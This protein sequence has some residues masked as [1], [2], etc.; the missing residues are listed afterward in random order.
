MSAESC[1]SIDW[2]CAVIVSKTSS[3]WTTRAR[4][5]VPTSSRIVSAGPTPMSVRTSRAK[6]S[7]RNSSSTNRPSLLNRS[8]MSVFSACRVLDSA[9]RIF[10]KNTHA[11]L[12]F[13]PMLVRWML[14]R[15]MLVRWMLVRSLMQRSSVPVVLCSDRLARMKVQFFWN[16]KTPIDR[17]FLY[18]KLV[19]RGTWIGAAGRPAQLLLNR[20]SL[21]TGSAADCPRPEQSA[22]LADR[23][24]ATRY[25]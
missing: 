12:W 20:V 18:W 7:S 16:A 13:R 5:L 1:S 4:S 10:G 14:V 25:R 9:P 2:V 24:R 23:E 11:R 3:R 6:S 19:R 22:Q 21:W 17:S 8:R 15:W